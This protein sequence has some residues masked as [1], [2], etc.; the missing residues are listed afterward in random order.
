MYLRTENR[1]FT[2]IELSIVLVIIGLI[3]GGIL[4]GRDL[5]AAA[6]AI[7]PNTSNPAPY[8]PAAAIGQGNYINIWSGIQ[9]QPAA[10]MRS[11]PVIF[12][13]SK[14]SQITGGAVY[15]TNG[16]TVAQAY[17]MDSKID[18]G[19]PQLGRAAAVYSGPNCYWS[20]CWS[21]TDSCSTTS[22]PA[23]AGTANTCFDNNN[24]A[25]RTRYSIAENSA[26]LNCA[27]SFKFQ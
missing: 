18:D 14:V 23:T 13:I 3:I 11:A 9:N 24:I 21:T 27:L 7:G 26:N 15:G 8:L 2:L 1:G 17:A 6:S 10:A 16:L 20:N 4:V 12:G 22:Q 25:G 19:L 5:I